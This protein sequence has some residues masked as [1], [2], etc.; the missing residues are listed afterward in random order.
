MRRRRWWL[1]LVVFIVAGALS[2]QEAS[3]PVDE[4]PGFIP[5]FVFNASNL[6]LDLD[7]YQGGFGGKLRF[8]DFSLRAL[9]AF[10]YASS[11]DTINGA[12]GITYEQPFFTGRITPYWGM[13]AGAG[14]ESERTGSDAD[15][16]TATSIIT[17]TAG[18]V[19]GAELLLF[20]F[21]SLF[22]EYA[23]AFDVASTIVEQS[24]GGAV[25]EESTLNFAVGTGLG[26]AASIGIVLYL[27][28][29]GIVDDTPDE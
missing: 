4:D 1:A 16:Y 2:A 15:N 3:P 29:L 25:A 24:T 9:L 21:L 23:L 28:P 6:L 22:A 11:N 27:Q 14:Y 26:N 7:E 8:P 10:G 20:D 18:V 13:V 12:L 5:G 19:L 17:G